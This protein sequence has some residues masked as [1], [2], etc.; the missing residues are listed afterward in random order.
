MVKIDISMYTYEKA[1]KRNNNKTLSFI[2][3]ALQKNY[4]SVVMLNVH[5]EESF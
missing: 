4:S 1:V 2:L 5:S 3:Q